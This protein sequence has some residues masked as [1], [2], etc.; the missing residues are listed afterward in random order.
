MAMRRRDLGGQE[1]RSARTSIDPGRSSKTQDGGLRAVS[2]T[3]RRFAVDTSSRLAALD[4][5]KR[6]SAK[7]GYGGTSLA[8]RARL[9]SLAP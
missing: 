8:A 6:S 1:V 5:W 4:M 9:G 3:T 2:E 7:V